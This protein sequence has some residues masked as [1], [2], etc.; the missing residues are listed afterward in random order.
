MYLQARRGERAPLPTAYRRW[1][2]S[3]LGAPLRSA[4]GTDLRSRNPQENVRFARWGTDLRGGNPRERSL[5]SWGDRPTWSAAP[6]RIAIPT[7]P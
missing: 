3:P 5:R 4:G 1:D 6:A 7:A 2:P